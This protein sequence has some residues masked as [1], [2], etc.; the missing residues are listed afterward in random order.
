LPSLL[1][2]LVRSQTKQI[3]ISFRPACE[4]TGRV[5]PERSAARI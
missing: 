5:P 3:D 2:M 4:F 1:R